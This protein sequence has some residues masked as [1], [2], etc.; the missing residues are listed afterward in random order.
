MEATIKKRSEVK[1]RGEYATHSDFCAIFI[2]HMQP[3]YLLALLLTGDEVRAE[4]CFLDGFELCQEGSS[5][6]KESVAAWSRRSVIKSAIK[7]TFSIPGSRSHPGSLGNHSGLDPVSDASLKSVQGLAAF[8]RF[9]FVMSV[10]EC[11]SDRECSLLLDCAIRD[12]LSARIRAFQQIVRLE[13][14]YP[15]Q[16]SQAQPYVVDPDWLECG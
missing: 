9:V 1:G 15:V 5:V 6:F 12:I 7:L 13:K 3:L 2:Q 14:S 11:Y 4:Q 10:L 16:S 8:D